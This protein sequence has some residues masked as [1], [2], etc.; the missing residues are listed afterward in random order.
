MHS[1]SLTY[2]QTCWSKH[3]TWLWLFYLFHWFVFYLVLPF[4][5]FR[6]PTLLYIRLY[7]PIWESQGHSSWVLRMNKTP[8][9]DLGCAKILDGKE[10]RSCSGCILWEYCIYIWSGS[11]CYWG[12]YASQWERSWRFSGHDNEVLL[13]SLLFTLQHNVQSYPTDLH[14]LKIW[15]ILLSRFLGPYYS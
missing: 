15:S 2:S 7:I 4:P 5:C 13:P 9:D 10:A 3:E 8:P 12:Y 1:S 11:V 14:L 6:H